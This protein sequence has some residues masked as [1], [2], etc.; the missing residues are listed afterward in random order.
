MRKDAKF[1]KFMNSSNFLITWFYAEHEQDESFYPSV[2]GNTSTPEYQKVYWKCVYDFYRSAS[3]LQKNPVKYLFFTNLPNIPTDVDGLNLAAFFDEAGIETEILELSNKTPKGWYGA[4]RSQFYLFDVLALLNSK[5]SGNFLILDSDIFVTKDLNAVFQ[6]IEKHGILSYDCG[7]HDTSTING[8][9]TEQMRMLYAEIFGI[10]AEKR[11]KLRY[12]GG[13]FIGLTSAVLPTILTCYRKL[14][15]SNYSL[16]E[17]KMTKL[18]EEA[19]F[20]SVIYHHLGKDESLANQYIKRMW[21]AWQCDNITTGDEQLALWHLPAEKKYLFS[22]MVKILQRSISADE[23][24]EILKKKSGIPGMR[25][26][27][28]LKRIMIRLMERL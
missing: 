26:M 23:Y 16:Y 15:E 8:I 10:K 25:C 13:E 28:K 17:K 21:T 24:I 9:S 1:Q 11:D 22:D 18:N 27:R 19:H 20:L 6:D 2:G 12:K 7:Y 5:Y 3:L 4:W 14:W